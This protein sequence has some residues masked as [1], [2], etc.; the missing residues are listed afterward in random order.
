VLLREPAQLWPGCR[1][2][3][4]L[5]LVTTRS[6]GKGYMSLNRMHVMLICGWFGLVAVGTLAAMALGYSLSMTTGVLAAAVA[7]VPPVIALTVFRGAPDRSTVELIYDA[8]H[9]SGK[10]SDKRPS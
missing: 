5:L 3:S 10:S 8:E 7:C 2:A 1:A 6:A 9:A 4:I